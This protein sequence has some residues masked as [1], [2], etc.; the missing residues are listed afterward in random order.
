[1]HLQRRQNEQPEVIPLQDLRSGG[2][3]IEREE[4]AA[5]DS[6][7]PELLDSANAV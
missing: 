3:T 5:A 2:Q 4:E 7:G 6:E 1:M